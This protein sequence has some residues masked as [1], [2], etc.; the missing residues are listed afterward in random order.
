MILLEKQCIILELEATGKEGVL[1]EMAEAITTACPAINADTIVE[2]LHEREQHGSTGVG[3]G[4][5]IPH[6]RIEGLDRTLLCFARSSRGIGFE[7]VDNRPV[8]LFVLLLSSE[9]KA[10][11]YLP[12]LSRVSRLLKNS[13]IRNKLM[14]ASSPKTIVQLFNRPE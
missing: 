11:E 6:G 14:Q 8:H 1:T 13:D 7:A 4:V 2:V 10:A 9:A 12:T 3:N 5:A